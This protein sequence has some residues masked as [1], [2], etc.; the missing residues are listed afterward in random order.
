MV[1][2][3]KEYESQIE[4]I[5]LIPSSGGAFEVVVNGEKIFSKLSIQRH[6]ESGEIIRLLKQYIKDG[7]L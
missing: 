6:A 1:E 5:T 7:K 3:L 4:S 2:F